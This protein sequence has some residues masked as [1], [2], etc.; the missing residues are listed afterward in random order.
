VIAVQLNTRIEKRIV[1]IYHEQN[2][3]VSAKWY[4]LATSHGKGPADGM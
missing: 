4:F 1:I 3:G 2:F